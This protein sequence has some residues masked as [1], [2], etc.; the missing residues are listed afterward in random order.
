MPSRVYLAIMSI[1]LLENRAFCKVSLSYFSM[2]VLKI[3]LAAGKF[4]GIIS[5]IVTVVKCRYK[6]AIK[7]V[8]TFWLKHE[9][10]SG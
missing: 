2:M 9:P 5:K 10:S 6:S 1:H 4:M 3:D 8:P 7:I